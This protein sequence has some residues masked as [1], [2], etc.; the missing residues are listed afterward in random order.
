MNIRKKLED[1]YNK[2]ELA[3]SEIRRDLLN[4]SMA[5]LNSQ[6]KD[7]SNCSGIC[8]TFAHN[9]MLITPLEAM[10]LL[11]YLSDK[12]RLNEE[13][14]NS[15]KKSVQEY[16][17]DKELNLGGG[18]EFRRNYTCPFFNNGSLGC[19]ISPKYKPYGCLGFNSTKPKVN[20]AGHCKVYT[21]VHEQREEIYQEKE[22]H[23]NQELREH[24]N[25]YWNKKNIPSAL[26]DLIK[27]FNN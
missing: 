21:E 10:E 16:R 1:L 22:D 4:E 24:Y 27:A 2:Y 12:N 17:L 3:K 11:G 14:V 18:R 19:S 13:L 26:L 6:G 15:L 8:C 25:L 5:E 7:C 9:S 20:E 23:I